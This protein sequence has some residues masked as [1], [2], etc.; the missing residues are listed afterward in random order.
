MLTTPGRAPPRLRQTRRTARPIV[1]L[2]RQPGPNTP[3]PELISSSRADRA[4]DDHERRRRV[5]R[6][7]DTVEVEGLVADG[8]DGGETTGRYSGPAAGH[9]RVDR[10]L[11][12][13]RAAVVGGDHRHQLAGVA[14]RSRD[15]AID[16][17]RV[18]GTTGSPS[19]TPRS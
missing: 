6:G 16:E 4:V 14:T 9:H 8:F 12:D 18:G 17:R 19:V 5:R 11:L 10:D 2:A 7:R 13:R 15:G 1:A 3:A